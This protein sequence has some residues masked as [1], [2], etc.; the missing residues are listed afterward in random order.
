MN[1]LPGFINL[2]IFLIGLNN[3]TISVFMSEKEKHGRIACEDNER[4]V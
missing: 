3:T 1:L 4:S 2:T